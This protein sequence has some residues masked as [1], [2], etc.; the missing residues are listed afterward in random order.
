MDETFRLNG[1]ACISQ[2]QELLSK[3]AVNGKQP[4][5]G[6]GVVI[7]ECFVHCAKAFKRSGLWHPDRWLGQSE[8]PSAFRIITAH[9]GGKIPITEQEVEEALDDSYKNR[10]Y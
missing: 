5:A 3:T 2:D 7:E 8:R 6:I 4:L 1:R 9:V 10:L